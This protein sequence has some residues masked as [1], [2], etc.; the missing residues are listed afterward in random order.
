MMTQG[1]TTKGDR[2]QRSY[3]EP[4]VVTLALEHDEPLEPRAL[5]DLLSRAV[6]S[7]SPPELSALLPDGGK[8]IDDR[9]T[10]T[11]EHLDPK[12][13]ELLKLPAHR[14][15]RARYFSLIRATL[16]ANYPEGALLTMII[17]LNRAV[18]EL[19]WGVELGGG[20]VLRAASPNWITVSAPKISGGG[21]PGTIPVPFVPA[22]GEGEPGIP[23]FKLLN[24]KGMGEGSGA[25][26][27]VEVDVAILDS[28]PPDRAFRAALG[29]WPEHELLRS[30]S[31]SAVL[32]R[33]YRD[34]SDPR[35]RLPSIGPNRVRLHGHDYPVSSHGLFVAGLIHS[36]AP[37]ARLRLIEVLNRYGVGYVDT[38]AYTLQRLGEER[39]LDVGRRPLLI[40]CSL[41]LV[42]PL[43]GQISLEQA[44]DDTPDIEDELATVE[45]I[46]AGQALA[47]RSPESLSPDEQAVLEQLDL[48]G[49]A[50]E[51]V[52]L[53]AR[54]WDV[55][56]VA[57]AGNDSSPES[58]KQQREARCPAAFASVVG[59]GAL[60][61]QGESAAY[62]N[63]ADRQPYQG[64]SVFGG[65]ED[66]QDSGRRP[67]LASPEYA[68]LGVYIGSFYT[69]NGATVR[70]R[71]N[72]NGWARWSGTS[73]A[74]PVVSGFVARL[75]ADGAAATLDEA[76][77][78]LLNLRDGFTKNGDERLLVT[79]QL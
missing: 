38:I 52:F 43:A 63:K 39:K 31:N 8:Q 29:R 36:I 62:S 64:L 66:H 23:G 22:A 9:R 55:L 51:W 60:D 14:A 16:G 47:G 59:V 45:T 76:H 79:Q 10:L 26:S 13:A 44:G 3:F 24:R 49:A 35:W 72:R 61:A 15:P 69:R 37:R 28:I 33:A 32:E 21:G 75:V 17:A 53:A 34:P 4:G 6:I 78:A 5:A 71:T 40:N 50:L 65:E 68:P 2:L 11:F 57:A 70:R 1:T 56:V 27:Q 58:G 48:L 54:N 25:Q 19:R 41:M 20:V 67:R 30:L 46:V 7:Q 77:K 12:A 73:F 74:A 18:A 42:A